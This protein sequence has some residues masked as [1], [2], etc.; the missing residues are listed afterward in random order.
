MQGLIKFSVM[1]CRISVTIVASNIIFMYG[2][3][4]ICEDLRQS[5]LRN[6]KGAL[7]KSL[8]TCIGAICALI[9]AWTL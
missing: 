2:I 6:G 9:L 1:M 8:V 5:L 3:T 4:F 7:I